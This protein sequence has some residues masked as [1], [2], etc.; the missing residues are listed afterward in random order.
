MKKISKYAIILILF[1]SIAAFSASNKVVTVFSDSCA[2]CFKKCSFLGLYLDAN[3][4]Y[5][6]ADFTV[7][8]PDVLTEFPLLRD[9]FSDSTNSFIPAIG[10]DF[11]PCSKVPFRTEINFL[12]ADINFHSDPLFVPVLDSGSFANDRFLIRNIMT[13]FY[14][15]WHTCTRFVPFIGA[16]AGIADLKVYHHPDN[17]NRP[18]VLTF[19]SRDKNFAWG[20]TLGTRYFFSNYLFANVQL[21]YDNLG[22]ITFKNFAQEIPVPENI[23][24]QSDYLHETTLLVGLGYVF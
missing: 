21:R 9:Y 24:Y 18:Q 13:T 3:F 16:S 15:D 20:A 12:Y 22:K 10:F 1:Y 5:T 2:P 6:W 8:Q 19:Q 7:H 11:Y 17:V 23:D 4:G 14:V